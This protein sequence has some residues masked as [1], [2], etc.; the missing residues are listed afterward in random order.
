MLLCVDTSG[1][2][3]GGAEVV[4]KAVVLEAVRTASAERRACHVFA[5]GGPGEVVEMSLGV[6]VDGIERLTRWMGQSFG[7]GTDIG[8][9]L[10]R[11]LARLEE[12][13]W[14]LADLLIAS[15]GEFGAT[16]AVAAALA[17][18][19][20]ERGLRVQGV[21]VGDRETLGMVELA[22]EIFWMQDWR[23]FGEASAAAPTLS[24]TAT[25]FPGAVRTRPVE[26]LRKDR[27]T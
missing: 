8:C 9:A 10:E 15:D 27:P 17:R 18:A 1:S 16:P 13:G 19:K 14:R 2:M 26:P 20:E 21:L 5:F 4:A 7:G 24:R 11:A 22:D 23:R 12:D 6:D 25:Y 3:S